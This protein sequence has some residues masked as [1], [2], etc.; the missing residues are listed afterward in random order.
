ML[1]PLPDRFDTNTFVF[2]EHSLT[3]EKIIENRIS[4]CNHPDG[5]QV[6]AGHYCSNGSLKAKITFGSWVHM[7]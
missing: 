4:K 5:P 1:S 2:P 7:D 6:T 3:D